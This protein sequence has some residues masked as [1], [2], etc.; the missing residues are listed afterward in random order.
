MLPEPLA[1]LHMYVQ[2]IAWRIENRP[3]S[4][5]IMEPTKV[6]YSPIHGGG[7]DPNKPAGWGTYEQAKLFCDAGGFAGV[8]FFLHENDPFWFLD[9]DDALQNGAWSRTAQELCARLP[10]AC[11]EI[12]W[13]GKGLH[14]IGSTAVP[15]PP[16]HRKKNIPLHIE[17]YSRRRFIALTGT[18]A[19]GSVS[20]CLDA[21]IS[22]I[23]AQY[24]HRPEAETSAEWTTT[25][26]P[27]WRGPTDDAELIAAA[28]AADGRKASNVF[29]GGNGKPTFTDI[30]TNNVDTLRREWPSATGGDYDRSSVDQSCANSLAF[31]TGRDCARI[32]R[33][34]RSSHLARP[35]W[36]IHSSY[37]ETTILKACAFVSSVYTSADTRGARPQEPIAPEIVRA[38]GF[39]PRSGG[40]GYMLM[41]EQL[42]HFAGCIYVT[43]PNRVLT[44]RG[45]KLDQAR[46]N[47][48]YGGHEFVLTQD[49]QKATSSA[50]EAFTENRAYRPAVA[51]RLCFRPEIGSGGIVDT[52][53]L[54]MANTY[55]AI[56]TA[57]T[58]GDPAPYLDLLAK[59]LPIQRDRDILLH[60]MASVV[61]N[62]GLKAQYWPVIQGLQGNAKTM[63]LSAMVFAVGEQYVHLPNTDK[64]MRNGMNFNGWIEGKLFV[65]LEEVYAADRRSFFEGFKTT[66][67]NERLPIE[68]KGIEEATYDN[69]ANGIITTNHRDG[70]PVQ[71]G[72][73]RYSI[74]FMA[75]QN[76]GDLQRDGMT[77]GYFADLHDWL[78]GRNAYAHHG[79]NYG[80]RVINQ[81][82]STYVLFDA[83][84][85]PVRLATYAPI[86][87]SMAEALTTSRGR[88]EQEIVEAIEEERPG[89]AGGWVSSIKLDE[90]LERYKLQSAIPRNKRR[91]MMQSLGYDL[92]P[93][94]GESGR[95][96]NNVM[97]ENAKPRLFVRL[98]SIPALNLHT[99][100]EVARAYSEAQLKALGDKTAAGQAFSK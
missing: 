39:T 70:V 19:I 87:S 47:A 63:H 52:G 27:E 42:D 32:E 33:I 24:F 8:G 10:G 62:P 99:A 89:F 96:N 21:P 51:D 25:P 100:L 9:F 23:V 40:G 26:D 30:W 92:H 46:F 17:F 34:M 93:A 72:D 43:G 44:P 14:V 18:Q 67:T 94:L 45:E 73:R 41:H 54:R 83:E 58:P 98:G 81:Y 65:G 6:P 74:F 66:V 91:E 57:K 68:G 20:T 61:Q 95:V 2:F 84:L 59:Q 38:A 11:V 75:Q 80:L 76:P 79:I 88:A 82:L 56:E 5:G 3:N 16:D 13:S 64:M 55:V 85:D 12:S 28:L 35:K 90:M 7:A 60:Y 77:P 86:T 53:S 78:K 50:W 15:L 48:T 71:A 4:N 49:G 1:P 37:L 97:P 69:R 31:W 22:A 36:D 29:G